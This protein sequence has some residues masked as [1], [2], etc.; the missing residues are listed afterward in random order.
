MSQ[1][2]GLPHDLSSFGLPRRRRLWVGK[3]RS[4]ESSGTKSGP[5]GVRKSRSCLDVAY[6]RDVAKQKTTSELEPERRFELLTCALRGRSGQSRPVSADARRFHHV[7]VT[8]RL[9][10]PLEIQWDRPRLCGTQLLGQKLLGQS[11]D[12]TI[13]LGSV[14]GSLRTNICSCNATGQLTGAR[15]SARVTDPVLVNEYPTAVHS[16]DETQDTPLKRDEPAAFGVV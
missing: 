13:D 16:P 1:M 12:R 4:A 5:E 14:S 7:L 6:P 10:V 2:P 15:R 8:M 3:Q 9:A 11:W